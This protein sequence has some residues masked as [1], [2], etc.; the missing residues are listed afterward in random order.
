MHKK[1]LLVSNDDGIQSFFLRTLV[2]ALLPHFEVIVAAPMKEQSWI[3]KAFTRLD[4]IEIRN[5]SANWPC[6]AWSIDGKPADCV[7]I[8][9]HHLCSKP[10]DAV[11]SGINLGYN[12]TLP[13][14]LSSGTIAAASEGA[15][16][17]LPAIALSLEISGDFDQV[18]VAHGKRDELGD[19]YTSIAAQ[20]AVHLIDELLN[21]DFPPFSLYS[22]NFPSDVSM[23]MEVIDSHLALCSMSSLF[24]KIDD[25]HLRFHFPKN[26]DQRL[27]QEINLGENAKQSDFMVVRSGKISKA[28]INWG[29][30]GRF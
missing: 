3:S 4:T 8:A 27:Y 24:E 11:I 23:D 28:L 16:Q 1:R 15:L 22:I 14:L 25:Q 6:E 18:R 13:L 5:E 2:E 7:N 9:I 30:L 29:K 26:W 20:R 12:I 17:G 21:Q 10:V 19:L